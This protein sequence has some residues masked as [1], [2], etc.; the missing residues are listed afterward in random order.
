M[1]ESEKRLGVVDVDV[2]EV[3]ERLAAEPSAQLIDVRTQ[4]EWAFVGVPDLTAIG[5][6]VLMVEWMRFPDN[7]RNPSFADQIA[8]ALDAVGADQDADLY[9]ICRSGVRSL[10]AAQAMVTVGYR[11]CHNVAS[12][13]EGPSNNDRRRG[14]LAGWKVVGLPW[15][16][17]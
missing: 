13:F 3:W 9:F 2:G 17:G 12:G 5:K 11:A 16:Q 8:L 4:A 1:A 15:L 14:L 6:Q 10:A 7:Q